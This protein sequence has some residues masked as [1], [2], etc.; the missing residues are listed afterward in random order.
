[1]RGSKSGPSSLCP[2]PLPACQKFG[3]FFGALWH[4]ANQWYVFSLLLV[5][6]AL[7]VWALVWYAVQTMELRAEAPGD[8]G[9]AEKPLEAEDKAA[10]TGVGIIVII[11]LLVTFTTIV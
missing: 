10:A 3:P 2:Y 7:E 9:L 4:I 11:L 5:W 6:V 8:L 1:M